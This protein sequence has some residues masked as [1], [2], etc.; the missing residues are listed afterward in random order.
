MVQRPG[1]WRR[2]RRRLIRMVDLGDLPLPDRPKLAE[3]IVHFVRALRHA[4]VPVGPDQAIAAGQ[5]V[6]VAG[7][8]RRDDLYCSLRAC[9]L[10]RPEDRD[11]FDQIFR[12]FWRDPRYGEHMLAMLLPQIKGT[13][14]ERRA[15]P[16]ARRASDAL[17]AGQLPDPPARDP[18]QTEIEIDASRTASET[19]RLRHLD[20]EQMTAQE[21]R[22]ARA[23]LSGMD[24]PV[25]PI[26]T[27]RFAPGYG[28]RP[29][30]RATLSRMMRHGGHLSRIETAKRRQRPP[31][32]VVLAD[33]SG[34]M[35]RY[36]RS[37]LH[38]IHA[39][40]Q[41]RKWHR[42]HGF[43]FGTRLT[44]ITRHL[45]ARDVDA[46]LA[47]AGAEAGDWEGGTR[48]ADSLR[49]F[50][51]DWSRRVLG[52]GAVVL[53]L[54]DGLERGASEQLAPAAQRLALSSRRLIW[55]NP[56]LRFDGFAPKAAGIRA[57]LPFADTVVPGHDIA[58][59]ENLVA[60]MARPA[61]P[62]EKTRLMRAL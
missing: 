23:I 58:S 22:A 16:A 60:A 8:A 36:S 5:A 55:I 31:V 49:A 33:I 57:I 47:A 43:T 39:T 1:L 56:L 48:I 41:A 24:L 40:M 29:D 32:L 19:E 7:I 27:R 12:L 26:P 4:G 13:Q 6:R 17:L 34:S 51:R 25:P 46:A 62:G 11:V 61:D 10:R 35:S 18:A 28:S 50:N 20:F 54:T 9:L 15:A 42:V 53:L 14:E 45:E 37:I 59:V 52:Q 3:N 30:P 44:N 2:L 21:L 38:F